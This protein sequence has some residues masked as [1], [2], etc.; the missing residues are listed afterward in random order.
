MCQILNVSELWIFL[1]FR[2]YDK[3]MHMRQY[4]I[5]EGFWIF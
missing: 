1:N 2:K 5:I 3:G 4:A